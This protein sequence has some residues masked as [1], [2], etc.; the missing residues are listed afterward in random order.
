MASSQKEVNPMATKKPIITIY[1]D[2]KSGEIV[3]K[4]YAESHPSTTE[5]ETRPAP[6]PR[7]K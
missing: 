6:K 4:K 5:K 3:T 2:A 7:G 1:R